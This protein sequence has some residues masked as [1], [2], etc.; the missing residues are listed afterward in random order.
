MLFRDILGQEN[1]KSQLVRMASD[2]RVPHALLFSGV[3]GSGGFQIALAL[4]RYLNCT[5]EK[6]GDACGTCPSC[7]KMNKL[8]HPDV[9]FV[10]PIV[11]KDSDKNPV[12]DDVISKWRQFVLDTPYFTLAQWYDFLGSEKQGMIYGGESQEI[13]RKLSLKTYE[14]R[15][16]IMIIWLPE[17]MNVS[18][19]NKLLK[20]LEEPPAHTLF[21]MVTENT[22]DI[23]PTILSRT[24]MIKVPG[25]DESVLTMQL[26]SRFG[27]D[28]QR[29]ERLAKVSGGS[30]TLALEAIGL[31]D[32]QRENLEDFKS[33]MRICY[34]R[35]MPDI[36]AF[37]EKMAEKSREGLKA[38]LDYSIQMVRENFVMNIND[39]LLVYMMPDEEEFARRF[40]PFIHEGNAFQMCEELSLA[41]AHIEQNGN[42]RIIM[43]DMMMKL[44]VLLLTP[45][46]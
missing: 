38:M 2:E 40:A 29:S 5:G 3:R 17:K 42:V 7:I 12:C 33:L 10:Y 6:Q 41:Q 24:Q 9:H 26:R 43:L 4:A 20:I 14:G 16:K 30:Y 22:G 8:V 34:S 11:K 1:I 31:A 19:A 32:Q 23:L 18:G 28:E 39:P 45:K 44:T 46:P 15:Y 25:I 27:I 36:I 37:S 35:K 13:I 21:L